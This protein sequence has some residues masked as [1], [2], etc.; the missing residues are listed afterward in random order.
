MNTQ[1]PSRCFVQHQHPSVERLYDHG[2]CSN[3]RHYYFPTDLSKTPYWIRDDMAVLKETVL[4]LD[5]QGFKALRQEILRRVD[6]VMDRWR[7]E[8]VYSKD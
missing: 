6:L 2:N 7:S 8:Q 5:E 4:G 3:G 1:P